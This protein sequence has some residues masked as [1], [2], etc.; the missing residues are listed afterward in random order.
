[1]YQNSDH[2]LL[3]LNPLFSSC[4]LGSLFTSLLVL[5]AAAFPQIVDLMVGTAFNCLLH[6]TTVLLNPLSW[7]TITPNIMF[8]ALGY[9]FFKGQD[10]AIAFWLT[11]YAH[12]TIT[13][14]LIQA[15]GNRS[16]VHVKRR[17]ARICGAIYA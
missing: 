3:E 17:K 12:F 14:L 5:S 15:L 10:V 13:I 16:V 11:A 4:I 7:I 9:F 8:C 2:R 1:M 6:P